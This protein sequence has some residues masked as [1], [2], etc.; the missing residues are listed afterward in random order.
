MHWKLNLYLE[1]ILFFF[2]KKTENFLLN[3]LLWICH[4]FH[5]I[6]EIYFSSFPVC[7]SIHISQSYTI[8][9]QI[10]EESFHSPAAS[11][12]PLSRLISPPL[13]YIVILV[14]GHGSF[15]WFRIHEQESWKSMKDLHN[16]SWKLVWVQEIWL[17]PS[18]FL[19]QW[20]NQQL[21]YFFIFFNVS[22]SES[23]LQI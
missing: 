9:S 16:E 1:I 23:L 17:N 20:G 13:S 18:S 3:Y 11:L 10:A 5:L 6:M 12:C 22:N 4:L 19:S 8:T 21:V 2:K 14:L 7:L 15:V